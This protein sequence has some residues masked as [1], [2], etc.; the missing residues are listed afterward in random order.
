MRLTLLGLDP[1]VADTG[2]VAVS[3]DYDRR[4]WDVWFKVWSNVIDRHGFNVS[5]KGSY[6]DELADTQENFRGHGPSFTGVEGYRPRGKNSRQDEEMTQLVQA[7][8]SVMRGAKI[9]DN[10]GIKKVVTESTL[11]LFKMSRF[12][13]GTNHADLKS[14]ARVALKAGIDVDEVN[15]L[16][17]EFMMDNLL[18]G[19]KRWALGSIRKL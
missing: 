5:V 10:T 15:T 1:G 3:L 8:R 4:V 12:N 18:E 6:L 9:I 19:G 17:A 11:K 16:L 14:A 7:S 2:F 13:Q